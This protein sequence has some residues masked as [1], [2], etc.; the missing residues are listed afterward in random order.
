M[1]GYF[2]GVL[3]G[4]VLG[5][6][7]ARRHEPARLLAVALGVAA[8]GFAVLWP[9]TVPAQAVAGLALLGVGLGNLFPMAISVAVSL[10]PGLAGLASGRAVAMSAFSVLL[11]PLAVGALADATSLKAALLA[12]PVLLGISAA[13]LVAVVQKT[14][15]GVGP[16]SAAASHA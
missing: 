2:V 10:A 14:P 1:G 16:T 5:S 7:L 4:R 12:L 9:A 6:R 8:L 11:A 15:S 3:V 13:A